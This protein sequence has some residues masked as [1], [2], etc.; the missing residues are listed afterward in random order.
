MSS[1]YDE[2]KLSELYLTGFG[3]LTISIIQIGV[4][5]NF[6]DG[7]KTNQRWHI[8]QTTA[9]QGFLE[10][11]IWKNFEVYL[12]KNK[13]KLQVLKAESASRASAA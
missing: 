13:K 7:Y 6:G 3:N 8:E 1:F 12:T 5:T 10:V 2:K 11:K 9:Q 4:R